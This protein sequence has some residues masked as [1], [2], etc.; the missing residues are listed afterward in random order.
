RP[1]CTTSPGRTDRADAWLSSR[2]DARAGAGVGAPISRG[3]SQDANGANREPD[4]EQPAGGRRSPPRHVTMVAAHL[5]A[6]RQP[7]RPARG[8]V[9]HSEDAT[10]HVG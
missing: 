1:G 7:R 5:V 10:G 6:S 3:A 2:A 4:Q 9:W 8:D